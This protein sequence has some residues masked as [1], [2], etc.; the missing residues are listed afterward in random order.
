MKSSSKINLPPIPPS[1]FSKR[2]PSANNPNDIDS[3]NEKEKD[4]KEKATKTFS[5]NQDTIPIP[6]PLPKYRPPFKNFQKKYSSSAISEETK[7]YVDN[8]KK[9]ACNILVCVRCR[10]LSLLEKQLSSFETIRIMEN[11]ML[12]LM[13]PIEYNGPTT[14]FKNRTREQTYAFDFA[15]DKYSSQKFVF[16]NSTKFLIEGVA[17]GYNATVFAYGATGAGKTYTMLGDEGNPGIM[18]LTLKELFREV[19]KYKEREYKMKFWYLEIY[20]ENIRD[21]LK[22]I[23]KPNSFINEDNDFLDLREDPIKGIT[24]SGITEVNVNNSND[25]LKIL[26]RGNRNRTIEATG[27]NE[28]SSRSH[29]I[30]QLSLEY[31]DR[32]SG[33]D[34]EIKYSKLSLV[35][36]A[37][38]ERASATQNRGLRLIEGGNINRSLLTLGNCINALCDAAS[39]GLKKIYVPY[40]DSKLTR[41][42]KDSLGGNARTVMIANVSPSINTFDDTY[43]TLK[44]ANRAKN[45]KTI[46]S[47]NVLNARY[48]IS[49][50]VNII[51]NLKEEILNLKKQMQLQRLNTLN[52]TNRNLNLNNN[53]NNNMNTLN[54]EEISFSYNNLNT[55]Q[56]QGNFH[57]NFNLNNS[58]INSG[59]FFDQNKF[60]DIVKEI[61]KN[62]EG[63]VSMKQ[64]II[65]GQNEINKLSDIIEMNKNISSINNNL[66]NLISFTGTKNSKDKENSN[67]SNNSNNNNSQEKNN[68]NEKIDELKKNLCSN[69][70]I[71]KEFHK[72]ID[73]IINSNSAKKNLSSLQKDFLITIIKNSNYKIQMLDIQYKNMLIKV[74]NEIK[75]NYIKELEKQIQYR[76]NIIHEN[77]IDIYSKSNMNNNLIKDINIL[78][79]DYKQKITKNFHSNFGVIHQTDS[80]NH[81]Y[82]NI[83]N[84]NPNKKSNNINNIN[85]NLLPKSNAAQLNRINIKFNTNNNYYSNNNNP[86]MNN[87]INQRRQSHSKLTMNKKEILKEKDKEN[88]KEKEKEKEK[89]NDNDTIRPGSK[90]NPRQIHI[91]NRSNFQMNNNYNKNLKRNNK[92]YAYKEPKV[93]TGKNRLIIDK[94]NEVRS[95]SFDALSQK[96]NKSFNEEENFNRFKELNFHIKSNSVSNRLKVNNDIE[97]RFSTF[98]EIPQVKKR[99]L[100]FLLNERNKKR[101]KFLDKINAGNKDLL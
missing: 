27:A 39:K 9:G 77:N 85:N 65:S 42:L 57:S 66:S 24:V 30:F 78:K 76:D 1:V 36:L 44:Y 50:Y 49:N 29:A 61:K 69:Q 38:S 91:K 100:N 96:H 54:N 41:L 10:P 40:R 93:S 15:F 98:E 92:S 75:N 26:K 43:N 8:L 60:K 53:T 18:P 55:N 101:Q 56:T 99:E 82:Q 46:V 14:V 90:A 68:L 31:K 74:K 32:N 20:N 37:G 71:Y 52:N 3:E 84:T 80:D 4:K 22:F 97:G 25:M 47:R 35:D 33:I 64:K 94:K 88:I 21:L 62:C 45:I 72:K 87:I 81:Y 48:H 7:T 83:Y 12:V 67:N 70:T 17:S 58:N 11:K 59:F 63:Q 79:K 28:T 95:G 89:E 86:N 73:K 34:Y 2:I 51:N 6:I 13:D 5:H 19:D 23:D 16:E